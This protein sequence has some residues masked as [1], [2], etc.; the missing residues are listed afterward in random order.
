M[1]K[2]YFIG[3]LFLCSCSKTNIDTIY[4]VIDNYAYGLDENNII[5]KVNIDYEI[6]FF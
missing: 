2:I 1:R 6:E 3:L 5:V 4:T